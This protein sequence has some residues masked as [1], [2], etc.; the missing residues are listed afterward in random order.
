MNFFDRILLGSA[1]CADAIARGEKSRRF[2]WIKAAT[3]LKER[4]PEYAIAGL[5]TD[6]E[7]TGGAIWSDGKPVPEDETYTYLSSQWDTPIL[8]I[9]E[10]EIECWVADDV[11][12]EY[13]SAKI[14]WPPE[15][16]AI[17]EQ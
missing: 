1:L 9:D 8:V 11:A 16:L 15:A 10:E 17:L 14:Y 5:Q 6:L 13:K 2:D 12:A 4:N 7:H 3:I